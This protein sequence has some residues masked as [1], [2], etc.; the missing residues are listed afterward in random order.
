[1][2]KMDYISDI[3][4]GNTNKMKTKEELKQFY[5]Y[6]EV[7]FFYYNIKVLTLNFG[8]KGERLDFV[9]KELENI[10]NQNDLP[11]NKKNFYHHPLKKK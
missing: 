10:S 5:F 11:F 8:I 3:I 1:M 7:I 2:F 4:F 6:Q 9:K